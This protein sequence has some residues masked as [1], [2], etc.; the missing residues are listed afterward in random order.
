MAVAAVV[1]TAI[2]DISE[3][4]SFQKGPPLSNAAGLLLSRSLQS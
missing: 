2:V 1:L 3:I 4:S